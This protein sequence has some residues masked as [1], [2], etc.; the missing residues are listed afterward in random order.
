MQTTTVLFTKSDLAKYPFLKEAAEYIKKLDLSI[1]E[2][3]SPDYTEILERAEERVQEAILYSI[4]TRKTENEDIELLSFPTAMML[5]AATGMPFI[6]RRYALA[7]AKQ[8][9]NDLRF[10]PKEKIL[11]VA[12]NFQWKID[13]AE[14]GVAPYEFKLHFTNYLRNTTHLKGKKWKLTNRL[15]VQGYVYLTRSEGAR[16]LSEEIRKHIEKRLDIDEPLKLP[17]R[18]AEK[19]EKIKNLTLA[20]VSKA[21]IEGIPKTVKKEAFPPCITALYEAASKGRHLSHVGRFTLTSFLVNIGLPSESVIDIFKGF[22]DFNE[23]LTRYQVEHIAGERGARTRYLPP[24][25]KT[26]ETHGICIKPGEE[27]RGVA[28]PLRFYK[29]K[30]KNLK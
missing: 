8:A 25:C 2:L 18:I 6:K 7:E 29:R 14:E 24:S 12:R 20:R 28:H 19:V 11:A 17:E 13:I 30:L 5:V 26:L 27:C 3:A 15:L 22:P 1:E 23:R 16:L 21:E 9:Y 4:I 10:E